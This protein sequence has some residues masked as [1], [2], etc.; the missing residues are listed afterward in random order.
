MLID[1]RTVPDGRRIECDVGIFGAGAA[2]LTI[3][4]EF[5]G[6]GRNLCLVE[7][8]GL[9]LD[10]A[11]QALYE[12][13]N[14][15]LPYFPLDVC[16]LRQFGGTT[17]HWGGV[18]LPFKPEDFEQHSWLPHSGWPIDLDD[19]QPYIE[20]AVAF[21]DLPAVGWNIEHWERMTGEHPFSFDQAK[22]RSQVLLVKPMRMGPVLQQEFE[23]A[24]GVHVYLNANAVEIETTDTASHVTSVR[25]QTL[26]GNQLTVVG[27][28]VVVALGG[29]ENP[30]LL[31]LSNRVQTEGLGNGHDLVGRFFMEHATFRGGIIQPTSAAVDIGFYR[32]I[33]FDNGEYALSSQWMLPPEVH[34]TEE[35]APVLLDIEPVYD[36][37]YM[38]A[39]VQSLRHLKTALTKRQLPDDLMA[40]IGNLLGD[41]GVIAA[42]A[43]NRVR[44]GQPPVERIDVDPL[45][46]PMPNPDSRVLLGDRTDAL[47]CRRVKLDWRLTELDKR[48]ARRALEIAAAEI[49]RL[50]I[51]RMKI[52]MSD[53]D[54][55]WPDDLE[56]VYHHLG[57]TRMHDDPRHGVVDRDCRVHGIDNLYIAGSSVFPTAGTGSPTLMIIALALRLADHLKG[58]AA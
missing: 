42:L 53:D 4:R 2:G 1:A 34:Q 19:M 56:G 57:T 13:D 17:N 28:L 20:R 52:T 31:L 7:S 47:G 46:I 24:R 51:G 15:G 21:L 23:Q 27:K 48:S 54:T 33:Q 38:S 9:E 16:R 18:C 41:F 50:E 10:P 32:K 30:R 29:I 12:G 49:G 55:T 58:L 25:V 6:S 14:V 43:V 35:I 44:Y 40:D 22:L 37:A 3:A 5:I 11:T 36:P 45:I 26:A 8:G 39:G